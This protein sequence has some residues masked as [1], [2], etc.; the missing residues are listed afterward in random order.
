M[1]LQNKS[2]LV[3]FLK[4]TI[5]L[6]L[7]LFLIGQYN[8]HITAIKNLG[9]YTSM[10]LVLILC[11]FDFN[12][13]KKNIRFN[14]INNKTLLAIFALLVLYILTISLFAYVDPLKTIVDF[15]DD[16]KKTLLFMLLII[17]CYDG[18]QEI[19]KYFFYSMAAAIC[20]DNIHFFIKAVEIY[21]FK[22]ISINRLYASFFD[23]TYV[24]LLLA[25]FF[26]SRTKVPFIIFILNLLLC[27]FLVLSTGV[28]GSWFSMFFT[29]IIMFYFLFKYYDFKNL[30]K[31]KKYIVLLF[32]FMFAIFL[33]VVLNSD[34][35][36]SKFEKGL[37]G[38]GR[39]DILEK[40]LPLL[41]DSSRF[42]IGL[43]YGN[44]QYETFLVHKNLNNKYLGPAE[45]DK[46]TGVI[47]YW[48][49]EPVFIGQFYHYGVIG[50]TLFLLLLF[51]V[52]KESI[53]RARN[54]NILYFA[55]F[56]SLINV[57]IF[58]GIFET[59][60]LEHLFLMI[61]LFISFYIKED[62]NT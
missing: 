61:S 43:G 8:E 46:D 47:K 44:K 48:H 42:F 60:S 21:G 10:V 17:I 38:S 7:S 59:I 36:R 19:S 9:L 16:F 56:G 4:K 3:F 55:I 45:I 30:I 14:I 11:F 50:T 27:F 53:R 15:F 1:T 25:A 26:T 28:R 41:Y 2:N 39:M 49:D 58:R 23:K 13:I 6:F 57:Y 62:K 35:V 12:R 24:F 32:V 51:Y 40:R 22:N 37:D 34:F 18:N 29:T 52:L 33:I 5:I 54:N 20:F 31:Y